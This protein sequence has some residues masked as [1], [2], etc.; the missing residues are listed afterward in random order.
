M[1]SDH[2]ITI[3]GRSITITS[4]DIFLT[5]V[6]VLTGLVFM[7]PQIGIGYDK[8]RF[9]RRDRHAPSLFR[10]NHGIEM[11]VSLVHARGADCLSSL[12]GQIGG[13]EAAAALLETAEFFVFVRRNKIAG[14]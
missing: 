4:H 1:F 10:L 9:R 6:S 8:A 5:I 12:V 2:V 14:N 3:A 7:A 11:R 13:R